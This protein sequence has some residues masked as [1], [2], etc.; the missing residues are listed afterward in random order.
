[1]AFRRRLPRRRRPAAYRARPLRRA[2][3]K[4]LQ[5]ANQ[6]FDDEQWLAA[7]EHFEQLAAA[8]ADRGFPQAP[9][10]FLRAGRARIENGDHTKGL[11]HLNEA[12]TLFGQFGQFHRLNLIRTRIVDGLKDHGLEREAIELDQ[13]IHAIL[14]KQG[15]RIGSPFQP[16]ASLRFPPKCTSCGANMRPDEIE[17]IDTKTAVCGYCGSVNIAE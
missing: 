2:A 13:T 7:A 9:Q 15:D 14:D 11:N 17:I 8:A 10:L 6:L 3:L 4:Q 5:R 16:D 1:M 12:V